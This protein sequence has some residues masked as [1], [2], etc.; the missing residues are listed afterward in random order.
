MKLTI[1]T[2]VLLLVGTNL[3]WFYQVVDS[4][5]TISYR[6]QNIF[7]LNETATQLAT[8]L[9]EIGESIPKGEFI[10]IASRHTNLEPFEKHGCIWVGWIGLK[11]NE[12]GQLIYVSPEALSLE[13]D[14]C[15]PAL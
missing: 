6:D 15:A 1:A 9:T 10:D 3:F 12:E 11:F 4:G 14:F 2:L 13:E 7:E 8:T 5:V